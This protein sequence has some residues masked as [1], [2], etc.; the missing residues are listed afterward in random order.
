MSGSHEI[1]SYITTFTTYHE[2]VAFFGRSMGSNNLAILR[3][4]N[5]FLS[6]LLVPSFFYLAKSAGQKYSLQR[7]V[8][9]SFLPPLFLYYFFLYT[10]ILSLLVVVWG[11]IFLVRGKSVLAAILYFASFYIRQ[12]NIIFLIFEILY[13]L[14]RSDLLPT[15]KPSSL[16]KV[17]T[18]NIS[19][20]VVILLFIA[21][22]V[23]FIVENGGV[24]IGDRSNHVIGL[25]SGNTVFFLFLYFVLL[26]PFHIG[27]N[28]GVIKN[29]SSLGN[30][31]FLL[32]GITLVSL[33]FLSSLEHPY[34]QI[35]MFL[36]NRC[37]VFFYENAIHK[38]F[39][40]IIVLLSLRLL[41]IT[42]LKARSYYAL[43]PLIPIA[44][45]PSQLIE[46]RYSIPLFI[47]YLAFR[48]SESLKVENAMV[49][50]S[51]II[52]TTLLFGV[53]MKWWAV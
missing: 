25:Y 33:L 12:T 23:L 11:T 32:V 39:Y 28:F 26:L 1:Y 6:L 49:V 47:L 45:V 21:I 40:S 43:F 20:F 52:S 22:E 8:Q 4:V 31:F 38:F 29:S 46:H 48:K 24:A 5:T 42:P 27:A 2:L 9:M 3:F 16:K 10:D 14:L 36:R 51:I 35:S 18:N 44:L 7:A 15:L 19:P 50:Y 30:S 37:L 34:N 41:L 13:L 17:I 53:L